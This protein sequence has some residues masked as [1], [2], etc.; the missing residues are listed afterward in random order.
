[1]SYYRYHVFFCTNQRDGKRPCCNDKGAAQLRD[2]A[3]EKAKTLG[4]AGPGRARINVAGCMERCQQGP[5]IA[6]YPEAVWYTYKNKEDID[7]IFS[8]HI[9]AGRIVTRLLIS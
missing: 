2:Y 8:E 9:M 4:L 5:V 6:I 7:E 1:M 3:K